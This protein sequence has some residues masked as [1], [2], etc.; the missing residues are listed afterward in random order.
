VF[1][2][3]HAFSQIN[4]VTLH[5]LDSGIRDHGTRA[6]VVANTSRL[7]LILLSSVTPYSAQVSS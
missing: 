5:Q 7:L 4:I 3:I 1:I 2:V 6:G